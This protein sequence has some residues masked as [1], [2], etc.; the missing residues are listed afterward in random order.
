MIRH[1]LIL[2]G[3]VLILMMFPN[4]VLADPT[5]AL[6]WKARALEAR[7][8]T[9]VLSAKLKKVPWESKEAGKLKCETLIEFAYMSHIALEDVVHKKEPDGAEVFHFILNG[10]QE[11][12]LFDLV[13]VYESNGALHS[14]RID[15]LPKNW[16]ITFLPGIAGTFALRLADNR[17]LFF[18]NLNNP[19][20]V[21]LLE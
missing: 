16:H 19:F 1:N 17:C 18:F 21:R 13:Y 4:Y 6:L 11:E 15:L 7:D 2:I 20:E 3:F 10:G 14:T 9:D 12:G 8:K 5:I